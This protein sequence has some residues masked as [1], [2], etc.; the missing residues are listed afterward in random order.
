MFKTKLV[1][2]NRPGELYDPLIHYGEQSV[3]I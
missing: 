1:G 2:Y 3:P